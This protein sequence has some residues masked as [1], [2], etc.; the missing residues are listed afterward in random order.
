MLIRAAPSVRGGLDKLTKTRG[1]RSALGSFLKDF[2]PQLLEKYHPKAIV[3]FSAHW[4]SDGQALG[5][6]S[7]PQSWNL[8]S[9]DTLSFAQ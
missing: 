8:L 7:S 1:P 6:S 2:G 3:I 4:E 9:S 5:L